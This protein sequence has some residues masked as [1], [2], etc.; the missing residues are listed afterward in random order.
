MN[1][2]WILKCIGMGILAMVGI[3]LMAYLVM[4]LWNWLMPGL[5]AG[6]FTID[7][8]HALGLLV[9]SKVLFG[10]WGGRNRCGGGCGSHRGHWRSRWKAKW[11]G[12]SEEER[13]KLRKSCG[14]WCEPETKGG[15]KD[16]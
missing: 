3:F 6:A 1:T 2:K 11:E 8:W 4:L 9:L 14:D 5:F 10:G 13:E 7:Y 15:E 12:M 16:K